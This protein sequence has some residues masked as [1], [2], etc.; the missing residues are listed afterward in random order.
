VKFDGE[1]SGQVICRY[2][3]DWFR[4]LVDK[5][6]SLPLNPLI[7]QQSLYPYYNQLPI[8][9]QVLARKALEDYSKN[10]NSDHR[11]LGLIV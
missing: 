6:F 3:M 7:R 10:A 1:V 5:P 8:D 2:M 4:R 9:Q 11:S